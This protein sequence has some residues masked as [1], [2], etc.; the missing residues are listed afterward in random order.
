MTTER[1]SSGKV[2][3]YA[4]YL[5]CSNLAV[6]MHMSYLTIF[7]T[8]QLLI[9]VTQVASVLLAAR[10][11]DL[12]VSLVC[13][14]IIE[15]APLP[16]GKYRSWL[17]L[18]QWL[19][20]FSVACMFF[21][22]TAWPVAFRLGLCF[23]G[24]VILNVTM[25]F[26]TNSYYA[27]GPVM[28][29]ANMDDRFRLSAT[30][31]RISPISMLIVNA[32]IIPSINLLTP[33]IGAVNAYFAVAVAFTI[34]YFF[35]VAGL[36]SAA[37]PYDPDGG[38]KGVAGRPTVTLRDMLSSMVKNP[39]ML[40]LVVSY[41]LYYIGNYVISGMVTYYFRYI[42]GNFTMMAVCSTISMVTGLVTVQFMPALG[43]KLGKKR[44]FIIGLGLYALIRTSLYFIRG[45]WI[46]YVIVV[47]LAGAM[48]YLFTGFGSN[49][50]VDAG[51]YYLY[52]TGVD[53]RTVA[54][55]LYSVPL[56]MGMMLGNYIGTMGLGLIGY[57]AGMT[58]TPEFTARFMALMAI[59]GP[60]IILLGVAVFAL[61][62]KITDEKAA[63]YAA[64][65]AK[66]GT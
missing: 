16:W 40:V 50:F 36:N 39:Q 57:R 43:K 54:V 21:N 41:S 17:K 8:D 11:I 4:F 19:V 56:K 14:P 66:L 53:T 37:K 49:Y 9:P 7:M 27:L 12:L 5:F 28:A 30:S 26:V 46:G 6:M 24:Y 64:E 42:V 48:S 18:G 60:A 22:T 35:G 23:A 58:V 33:V 13:G 29:G 20:V 1:L 52:E 15:K 32:L 59:V 63:F 45:N 55:S 3:R 2:F 62:Y 47:I 61:G 34:P 31:A 51:E 65:N 44:A 25:S 10:F 38:G